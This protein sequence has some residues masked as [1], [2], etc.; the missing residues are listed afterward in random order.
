MA[1]TINGKSKECEVKLAKIRCGELFRQIC[2][3]IYLYILWSRPPYTSISVGMSRLFAGKPIHQMCLWGIAC[4][5]RQT[6]DMVKNGCAMVIVPAYKSVEHGGAAENFTEALLSFIVLQRIAPLIVCFWEN[7]ELWI[8]FDL[9]LAFRFPYETL[10]LK[11]ESIDQCKWKCK[12][13]Q[14]RA[15]NF[16]QLWQR[17]MALRLPRKVRDHLAHKNIRVCMCMC[18]CCNTNCQVELRSDRFLFRFTFFA[19]Y[20][21]TNGCNTNLVQRTIP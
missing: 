19:F 17:K 10:P 20:Y 6:T 9:I 14:K 16:T 18:L 5:N 21:M 7:G 3:F 4:N 11:G 15:K 1:E 2:W 13:S 12:R 8:F